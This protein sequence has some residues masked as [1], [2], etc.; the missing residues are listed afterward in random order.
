MGSPFLETP[1]AQ[2]KN[3]KRTGGG[4]EKQKRISAKLLKSYVIN[5]DP[6]GN[7]AP[8]SGVR[9]PDNEGFKRYGE[10]KN[11]QAI[12][13]FFQDNQINKKT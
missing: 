7:R 13:R 3:F 2:S 8:V 9:D 10:F 6:T 12:H 1:I 4:R 5:G 11:A